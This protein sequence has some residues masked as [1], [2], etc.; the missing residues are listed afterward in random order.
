MALKSQSVS[1]NWESVCR[2]L[3][4]TL[5]SVC[6][7]TDS[8]LR[9][10]VV[11]HEIP[12]LAGFSDPR[13]EF[14]SV[15]FPAPDLSQKKSRQEDKFKKLAVGL[16]RARDFNPDFLML[17]DADDLVSRRLVEYA[18]AHPNA[19]GWAFEKGYTY[20]AGSPW[21]FLRNDLYKVCGT[22]AVINARLV[23]LP[24]DPVRD[25]EECVILRYG[26]TAI[27]GQLDSRGTPLEP[28]PFP[29]AIYV[30]S[31]GE[32]NASHLR[33]PSGIKQ[34]TTLLDHVRQILG[35]QRRF[36]TTLPQRKLATSALRREFSL[37]K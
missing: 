2:I 23:E 28:L 22:S 24:E 14:L 7:Q 18:H 6:A 16:S 12:Q 19:N 33:Q 1:S 36:I 27:R 10:F 4:K 25:F 11:C 34:P 17:M 32:N 13:V 31:H 5:R 20:D 29:G 21:L 35:N 9:V 30:L 15:D 37:T 3:E 26:H 8:N